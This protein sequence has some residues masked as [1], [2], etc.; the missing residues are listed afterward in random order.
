[1]GKTGK[2]V[3]LEKQ[4]IYHF[5]FAGNDTLKISCTSDEFDSINYWL[6]E[7]GYCNNGTYTIYGNCLKY[8]VKVGE[9]R[10]LGDLPF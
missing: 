6:S 9:Q 7:Y 10:T 4:N 2:I 3:E 5:H 8:A 1:M